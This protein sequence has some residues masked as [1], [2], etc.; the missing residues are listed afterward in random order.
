M[1]IKNHTNKNTYL[2]T[3]KGIWVRDF[4]KKS[5]PYLDIN[6]LVSKDDYKILLRNEL[7]NRVLN[8]QHID[9]EDFTHQKIAIVSDG[10]GFKEKQKFLLDLPADVA[11][12]AVNGALAGWDLVK[13]RRI[14]YYVVNN[15]YQECMGFFPRHNR[16]FPKC[17][18]SMRT[19]SEF[20]RQYRKKGTLYRYL[21]TPEVGFSGIKSDAMYHIDDYRNPI[22][23]AINLAYQMGVEK[24]LLFACDNSFKD[25]K[26]GSIPLLNEFYTYPQHLISHDIIDGMCYWLRRQE[27]VPFKVADH[28]SGIE[29]DNIPY[30]S[31]DNLGDFFRGQ[32]E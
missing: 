21:A 24:L 7:E 9:T 4:T 11:V 2:L 19:H 6:S 14:H 22:C 28:S 32:N 25:H 3:N 23:A 27:D 29:Y 12:I 26:A 8:M 10:F 20:L 1:R 16:Y 30:I 17:I 15:P 13:Q 18:A 31:Q 5:V